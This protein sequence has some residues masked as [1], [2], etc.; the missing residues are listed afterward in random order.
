MVN[1]TGPLRQLGALLTALVDRLGR[2]TALAVG[3]ACLGIGLVMTV[4]LIGGVI[5]VP[6]LV[7]GGALIQRAI[8]QSDR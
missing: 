3:V 6:L 2:E 8:R 1:H 7:F 4:T 5:G